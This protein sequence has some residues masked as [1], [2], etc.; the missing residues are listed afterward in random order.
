MIVSGPS[1]GDCTFPLSPDL[2]RSIQVVHY[3]ILP[4][5]VGVRCPATSGAGVTPRIAAETGGLSCEAA[6]R[7]FVPLRI[8]ESNIVL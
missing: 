3:A 8:G 7:P 6:T 2:L 5:R 1:A 4:D